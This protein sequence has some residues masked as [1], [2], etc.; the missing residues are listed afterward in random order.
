LYLNDGYTAD[1]AQT[2]GLVVNYDP[3]TL[4]DTVASGGFVAGVPA[5]SNPTVATTGAATYTVGQLVQISNAPT[6]ANN[7]LFEVL[8]HSGNVLTVRG[9]GTTARLEDFTQNQ[10]VADTTVQG[11][12]TH[13]N[14][15]VLRSGTDGVWEV[16]AGNVTPLSFSDLGAGAG[17]SLNAAYVV[18]NTITTD[19][20]NGS[21]VIG[22]TEA[23]QV[24][25]T[26]G[27]DVD[28]VVD[29]DVSSFDLLVTAGAFSLDAD[30]ASNVSVTGGNLTVSTLTTGNVIIDAV[31]LLDLNAGANMDIDVTGTFDMLATGAFSIDGT[32]ASNVQADS[33]ALT[34][35]TTTSGDLIL[36]G[37][38][39]VLIDGT[40]VSIDGTDTMNLT[41][42][43]NNAAARVLTISALNAGAG[44]G[45][46][47]LNAKSLVNVD[48]TT[49]ELDASG[50][51][52]LDGGG[53]SN[54]SATAANLTLSTITSGTLFVTS[55]G[56]LDIDAAAN[57]DMDVTGTFDLLATGAM[58]LDATGASNVSA[59]AGDLT[60]STITSGGL[61]LVSAGAASYTDPN[62]TAAA[63]TLTDGTD[64]YM[65]IDSVDNSV[66]FP[67]FLSIQDAGTPTN[68]GIGVTIETNAT[69]A[70]GDLVQIISDGGGANT[71]ELALAD[72]DT[73]N[74]TDAL[75]VGVSTGA[76]TA[77][78]PARIYAVPGSLIPVRFAVA[79]AA[80]VNGDTVFLSTTAG[81]A[82]MTAP[83]GTSTTTFMVGIL[84]GGDGADTTPLVLYLPR[85]ISSG[86]QVT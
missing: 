12:I 41:M 80:T 70:V 11:D 76:F 1:A 17:N 30:T 25:A 74:L 37:A 51:F 75:V 9:V 71:G 47:V 6:E 18:G 8:S 45:D 82:T 32:G 77:G 4:T 38:D 56:L 46:L 73:G 50:A 20:G 27:L 40:Q 52:S 29:F 5:T 84:Q 34:V 2:G 39:N 53:P 19:A 15:S 43:A 7:G 61:L 86:P 60:L 10:F 13:I 49:I 79:P 21:V 69:L 83:T 68:G 42:S 64:T 28:T 59:T 62:A 36:V 58:S 54:V 63:L 3:T 24:T 35:G 72:A 81:Q 67:E 44:A 26:G 48:G 22:G 55:A 23:L 57:I 31:Q 78:N 85:H 66:E 65:I 14:I 33:G 16:A